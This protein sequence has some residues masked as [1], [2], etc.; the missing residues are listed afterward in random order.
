M[1]R[2][3]AGLPQL[4]E[5][6]AEGWTGLRKHFDPS[7]RDPLQARVPPREVEAEADPDGAECAAALDLAA[8]ADHECRR[9]TR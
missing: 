5:N 4:Q 7:R 2:H 8:R 6:Y 1:T 3:A 9:R